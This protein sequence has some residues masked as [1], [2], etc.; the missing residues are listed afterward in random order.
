MCAVGAAAV[1]LAIAFWPARSRPGRPDMEGLLMN[2][3][4]SDGNG[5]LQPYDTYGI[6]MVAENRYG[7]WAGGSVDIT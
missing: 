2:V 1:V 7:F 6:P 3:E 5:R 4:G